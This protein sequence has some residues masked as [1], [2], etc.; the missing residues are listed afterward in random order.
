MK[1]EQIVNNLTNK[2]EELGNKTNPGIPYFLIASKNHT[3]LPNGSEVFTIVLSQS[4]YLTEEQSQSRHLNH[5]LYKY[6]PIIDPNDL[7]E[8]AR[9]TMNGPIWETIGGDAYW[10]KDV[11]QAIIF[12]FIQNG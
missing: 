5:F 8:N 9:L 2:L 10:A 3:L 11:D 7:W 4:P 6:L 12:T 1:T